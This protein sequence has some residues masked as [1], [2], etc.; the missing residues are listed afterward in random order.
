[1]FGIK[2]DIGIHFIGIGGIG[3]SGI[4]NVLLSLGYK[5]SGSDLNRNP[6][7]EKLEE[8][9]AKIFIGHKANNIDESQLIVVSSAINEKNPEIVQAKENGKP[10]IKRAEMLAE[11]MRLKFGIAVAGSHGKTTTTSFLSTILQHLQLRP[12]CIVG[13]V[14]K[15]LGGQAIHGDSEYL[16]A[17]A[18]ESDGSFLFLNPIMSVITNIDNDHMD[19]YQTE[20]NIK[21]AFEEF[22]NKVPFYG[23]VAVNL[24]D[25]NSVELIDKLRRRHITYG[26][27]GKNIGN[28]YCQY[29]ADK[30]NYDEDG[31]HFTLLHDGNSYTVSIA[32]SGEHNVLNA[33][34]AIAVAHQLELDLNEICSAISEFEG[35]GRRFELLSHVN[36]LIIVDDYG[37]HPTELRATIQTAKVRY[38]NKN[39]VAIF[40]PH[41]FSRTKE[42]WDEFVDCFSEVKRVYIAP[43]YAASEQSIPGINSEKLVTD[44]N[45]KYENAVLLTEW[46][47]LDNIFDK[48]I[49]TDT[50]ILSMGAGSISKATRKVV[51]EWARSKE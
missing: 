31:S 22:A 44:I 4:A 48:Y 40:E 25:K 20:E 49:D 28:E 42:F 39:I 43:I 41:R 46:Q 19:F 6:N 26:I 45:N 15:N 47:E 50:V 23:C 3:M 7:V 1:M 14:V 10:I 11:L 29:S 30:I 8:R 17:E 37:H 9:G 51:E 24:T 35:V 32:L 13:G 38:P 18:D 2:K 33:L 36:K 12:T 16:V 21:A 34:A 5:V 27:K